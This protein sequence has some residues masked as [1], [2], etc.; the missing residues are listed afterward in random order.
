MDV[1]SSFLTFPVIHTAIGNAQPKNI[2][3]G[4]RNTSARRWTSNMFLPSINA[5]KKITMSEIIMKFF[6][7]LSPN[8]DWNKFSNDI[9][10]TDNNIKSERIHIPTTSG[11]MRSM[12]SKR[13]ISLTAAIKEKDRK[14]VV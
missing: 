14:S 11:S 5:R 7:L 6:V 1:Y 12:D 8:K 13:E 2:I 10:S 9:N 4:V 3:S